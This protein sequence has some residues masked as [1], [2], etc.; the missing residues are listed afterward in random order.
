V[1][2]ASKPAF[3]EYQVS[4]ARQFCPTRRDRPAQ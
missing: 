3:C 1:L 4:L 2:A